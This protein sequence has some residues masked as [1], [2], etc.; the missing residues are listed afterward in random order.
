MTDDRDPQATAEMFDEEASD[1]E[2]PVT[3]GELLGPDGGGND[4]VA[5]LVGDLADAEGPLGP[6]DAA[7]H[8]EPAP[9]EAGS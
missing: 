6:E 2:D 5:E 3:H 1:T 8:L 7:I 9:P 4:D